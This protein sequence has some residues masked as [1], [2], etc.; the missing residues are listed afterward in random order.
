M[1]TLKH[2]RPLNGPAKRDTILY[3]GGFRLPDVTASAQRALEN[4]VLFR[5]LGYNV[6]LAGKLDLERNGR[7]NPELKR[8]TI[9]GFDCYDIRHPD[10]NSH[11][12]YDRSIGSVTA[13][14]DSIGREKI[15]ALIAYNYPAEAL[16]KLIS[17]SR[18]NGIKPV[19][20]CT[21]WY[22]WEGRKFFRNAYRLALSEFRM[23]F[24][25]RRSGNVICASAYGM[26]FYKNQKTVRLPFVINANASKW[27]LAERTANGTIRRFVYAG[28]P[29][30]GMVKDSLHTVIE[31][32]SK[33]GNSHEF[34]FVVIG[35]TKDQFLKQCPSFASTVASLGDSLVFKGRLTHQETLKEIQISDLFVF[36]RPENRVSHFGFPTKLVEAFGCGVPTITNATSDIG[37]YISSWNNGVLVERPDSGLLAEALISAI[38][39]PDAKLA[40]M[41]AACREQNPFHYMEFV[42]SVGDF[43]RNLR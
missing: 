27:T 25:A 39:I 13:I 29:G 1:A 19:A 33:I 14:A 18:S 28:S 40:E 43:L 8:T 22:G 37:D 24:A 2:S 16:W 36:L 15:H 5:E 4:A 10:D 21:E 11:S 3:I 34:Q 31:A 9:A 12:P 7:D 26:A 42:D 32:F 20:E 6:V 30:I 38:E 41:K 23:R 35:L 17:F